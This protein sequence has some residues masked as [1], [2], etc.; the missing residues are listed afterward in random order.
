VRSLLGDDEIS[1]RPETTAVDVPGWDSLAGV[2]IVF[3]IE[4][5]FG[6]EL[7]DGLSGYATVGE[8][9]RGVDEARARRGAA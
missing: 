5:E 2:N 7:G 6:I 3:G 4:E 1:L 9:A 8:L